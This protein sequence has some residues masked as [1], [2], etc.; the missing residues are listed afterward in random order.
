MR[1][2]SPGAAAVHRPAAVQQYWTARV[3]ML[4]LQE[5]QIGVG[6]LKSFLAASFSRSLRQAEYQCLVVKNSLSK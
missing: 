2:P 4:S 1:L 3:I 6:L 5:H